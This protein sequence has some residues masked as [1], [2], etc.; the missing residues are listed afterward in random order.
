MEMHRRVRKGGNHVL[1]LVSCVKKNPEEKEKDWR[2]IM[3]AILTIFFK[4]KNMKS[5]FSKI[6]FS[7]NRDLSSSC[8][9]L[10]SELNTV[11]ENR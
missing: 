9:V 1:I 7:F 8:F 5:K 6:M 3:Y 4:L 11:L 2:F 10:L